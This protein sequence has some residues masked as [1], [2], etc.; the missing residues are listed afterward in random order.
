MT[1]DRE[2]ERALTDWLE[3]Q[4]AKAPIDLGRSVFAALEQA[5]QRA[6]WGLALR[7]YQVFSA[8]A[9]RVAV[10]AVALVVAVTVGAVWFGRSGLGPGSSSPAPSP[11]GTATAAPSSLGSLGPDASPPFLSEA[12]VKQSL[13]AGRYQ[14]AVGSVVPE[15]RFE[16]TLPAGWTVTKVTHS[17]IDSAGPGEGAPYLGFFTVRRVYKDPC[18]PERGYQ[19]SYLGNSNAQDMETELSRLVGFTATP[20]TSVTI[21]GYDARRFTISNEIDTATAGCTRGGLLPLFMT[22]DTPD[23]DA[24]L[25]KQDYSPATSG[26]TTEHIWIVNRDMWGLLIVAEWPDG[27]AAGQR[28]IE[29]IL[30]SIVIR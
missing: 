5:P 21:G 24:E 7:R 27:S 16:L 18:H 4:P 1:T 22:D 8:N 12:L 17:E 29:D 3:G 11:A 13:A 2:L 28:T 20:A 26:G 9:G 25:A 19:G 14:A 6:W 30:S 10:A 15:F 23:R